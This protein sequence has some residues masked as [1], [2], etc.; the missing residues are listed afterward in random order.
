MKGRESG[1]TANGWLRITMWLVILGC[2]CR[3]PDGRQAL[4]TNISEETSP[5][6]TNEERKGTECRHCRVQRL[7]TGR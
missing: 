6:Q 3:R 5:L 1:D 7:Q 2:R 4:V